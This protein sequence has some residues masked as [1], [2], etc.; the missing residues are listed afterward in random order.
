MLLRL[1]APL[2]ISMTAFVAQAAPRTSFVVAVEDAAPPWSEKDG[3]GFANEIVKAAFNAAH[4]DV[5]YLIQPYSRCKLN[6]EAG[7]VVACFSMS[8]SPEVSAGVVFS[9]KPLFV[10]AS[11]YYR[12]TTRPTSIRSERD[13]TAGTRIGTVLDYEYPPSALALPKRGVIFVP[14]RSEIALVKKLAA[15]EIDFALINH[16]EIKSTEKT[17]ALSRVKN[18]IEI[19]FSSGTLES[20]IGFSRKHARG[21]WLKEKFDEGYRIIEEN[22]TLRRIELKWKK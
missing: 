16:N 10:F 9:A 3:T 19:A 4:I 18:P 6:A 8:Y 20:Y 13:I 22:G 5:T 14:A 11:D 7:T 1:L 17:I 12:D 15:G 21:L 2:L